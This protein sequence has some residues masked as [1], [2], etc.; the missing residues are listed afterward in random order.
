M[1]LFTVAQLQSACYGM[2]GVLELCRSSGTAWTSSGMRNPQ[3]SLRD[4]ESA[5][6]C[7]VLPTQVPDDA[8]AVNPIKVQRFL[9]ANTEVLTPANAAEL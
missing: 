3:A 4:G 1:I 5:L 6:C 7:S 8:E 2:L 9:E